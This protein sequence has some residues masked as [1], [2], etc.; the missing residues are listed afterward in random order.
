MRDIESAVLVQKDLQLDHKK[1]SI[2]QLQSGIAL[3]VEGGI[4]FL[5]KS[6]TYKSESGKAEA[7][8]TINAGDESYAANCSGPNTRHNRLRMIAT[9]TIEAVEKSLGVK[10][11]LSIGDTQKMLL[12]GQNAVVVGV[13]LRSENQEEVLLGTAINKGDD[14]EA[15]VRAS[16]DAINRKLTVLTDNED[17]KPAATML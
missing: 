14:L 1:I 7:I 12:C 10:H 4:R 2:A 15:T 8:V 17:L 5:F 6:V 13:C 11:I 9:A 3:P 16:L